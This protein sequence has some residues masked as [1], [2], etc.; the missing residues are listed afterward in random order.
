MWRREV[1]LP[2]SLSPSSSPPL[3]LPSQLPPSSSPPPQ[4]QRQPSLSSPRPRSSPP[5]STPRQR[6]SSRGTRGWWQLGLPSPVSCPAWEEGPAP[7]RRRGRGRGGRRGR[8]GCP[9][10]GRSGSREAVE[11]GKIMSVG[12]EREKPEEKAAKKERKKE[13]KTHAA[14]GFRV[15]PQLV[16]QPRPPRDLEGLAHRQLLQSL[17]RLGELPHP[18]RALLGREARLALRVDGHGRDER[19]RRRRRGRVVVRFRLM[20]LSLLL[21]LLLVFRSSCSSVFPCV[22]APRRRRRRAARRLPSSSR[23]GGAG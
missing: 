4:Q 12:D 17:A 9:P 20:M 22:G 10:C 11:R 15:V 8:S 14:K 16:H 21:L 13:K 23:A 5:A 6:P 2:S 1:E 18:G 19:R 7:P 3:P